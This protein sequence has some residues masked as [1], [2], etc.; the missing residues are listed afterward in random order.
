VDYCLRD[1]ALIMDEQF[2]NAEGPEASAGA[3]E[4]GYERELGCARGSC[5][6]AIPQL[7]ELWLY[8][9]SATTINFLLWAVHVS[10]CIYGTPIRMRRLTPV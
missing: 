4:L 1:D 10:Q 8:N 9:R 7:R 3:D 5:A 2:A 6:G